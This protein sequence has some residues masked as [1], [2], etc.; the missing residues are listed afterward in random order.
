[1]PAATPPPKL[2]SVLFSFRNEEEALPELLR[3]LRQAVGPLPVAAE[4]IFV[5]DASTDRS[6]EILLAEARQDPRVKIINLSRRFGVPEGFLAGMV[7]AQGDAVITLDTD[8]QDPPEVIPALVEKWLAGADVV[9]TIRTRREGEPALKRLLTRLAY[10]TINLAANQ[11]LLIEAGDFKLIGRRIV[12]QLVR[13]N[14]KDPYL[15]GLVTWM[16]FKQES[17]RY[18]REARYRGQTHFPLFRSKGPMLTF[19]TGLTSF[20]VLPLLGLLAG[21]LLLTSLAVVG[22]TIL[23]AVKIFGAGRLGQFWW[24]LAAGGF[25][26]G[27][28]LVGLGIVGLY[29]SRIYNDVRNRPHFIVESTVGL[30]RRTQ[31]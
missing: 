27:I 31:S 14:E 7:H 16:G 6:L 26:S 12:D 3:R 19:V 29:L 30:E 22:A 25:F 11:P 8:L 5:N 23:F 20:S 9:H 4:F 1:M 24:L 28:Q 17:V 21:G 13:L 10:K 18:R 2:L 15:R